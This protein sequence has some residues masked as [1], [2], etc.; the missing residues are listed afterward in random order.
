[1]KVAGQILHEPC[2]WCETP[3]AHITEE[4]LKAVARRYKKNLEYEYFHCADHA[5]LLHKLI[6]PDTPHWS[7]CKEQEPVGVETQPQNK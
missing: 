4:L 1:M 5:E 3:P 6:G 7:C 2:L